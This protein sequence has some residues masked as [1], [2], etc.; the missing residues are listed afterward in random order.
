[1]TKEQFAKMLDGREYREEITKEESQQAEKLGLCVIFGFSDDGVVIKG[2]VDEHEGAWNGATLLFDKNGLIK[3][4]CE[5]ER[6][7]YYEK[8]LEH[9]KKI[10]I[11][12]HD[13]GNPCWTIETEI[14]HAKFNIMEDD[15]VYGEGIVF[16]MS[17]LK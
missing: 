14:P 11:S 15:E 17:A 1:M 7:P 3:N 16:E 4:D 5:D 8:L 10:K 6:C 13:E 9:G 12:W 2:V